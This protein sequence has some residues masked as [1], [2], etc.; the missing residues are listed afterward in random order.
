M[1]QTVFLR[2][3]PAQ[4]GAARQRRCVVCGSPD[5]RRK[6][7]T[8]RG[9]GRTAKVR[10]C[11][12]CGHVR[13]LNN[14]HDYTESVSVEDLGEAT[15][16]GTHDTKGREF[17]MAKLAAEVLKRPRLDVLVFGAGRSLDNLHIAKLPRVRRVAV[18]DIMR[19]RD[20]ADFVDISQPAKETFDVVVASEVIEHFVN[21]RK[22]FKQMFGFVHRAG[23]VVCSTN[24]YDGGN[25]DQQTYI[26]GRG[27]VSYYTPAALRRIAKANKMHVDFR[28]P[29]TST[30]AAGPRKRY[31]IFSHSQDVMESLSDYFGANPYAPSEKPVK[32][33]RADRASRPVA[34][35]LA[36]TDQ[37]PTALG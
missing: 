15:R 6:V 17:G 22:D 32:R 21:P 37:P 18:G 30:G 31:V 1:A 4:G 28:L 2:R 29:L 23:I 8:N 19:V 27:H 11:R 36:Q 13:V 12:S 5:T 9:S 33:S 3:D 25:L 16:C 35:A 20:E 34:H 14:R 24:L 26:F 10:R 7:V